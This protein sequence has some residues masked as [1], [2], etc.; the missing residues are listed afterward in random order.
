MTRLSRYFNDCALCSNFK[1]IT[2]VAG[3]LCLSTPIS[4]QNIGAEP[5]YGTASLA[6]GFMPDPH[7]VE[8]AAGGADSVG[9]LG[10]DCV[11]FIA[12]GQPDYD[13][14]YEADS[15]Q[16]GFFVE[17]TM[18]TTLVIN[19]PAGNWHCN[20]DAAALGATNPGILFGSPLS[21]NYNIWVG[22]YSD[23]GVGDSA[24]LVI[25]EWDEDSWS[26]L[27]LD[28]NATALA[29]VSGSAA[30][31]S[32]VDFGDDA[33]TWA[34][35]DECDDQ[36]FQGRGMA[37]SFSDADMFHDASD[38]RRLFDAGSI[39]LIN[40]ANLVVSSRIERGRLRS[41][42]STRANDS[43]SDTFTFIADR[44]DSA[45]ID[46]RSGEFDTYLIVRAPGGEEF[47]N[48]DYESSFDRSLLSLTLTETGIYE[49]VVSSYNPGETGGY[50]VQIETDAG[51][52]ADINT[53]IQG[54][55]AD[56]D[57]TFDSG[58]FNDS[59]S[60][61]GRPGQRVTLDLRSDEFDT[62]LILRSPNGESLANDD[63]ENTSHS[64]IET[65]L[66]ELG[67]YE[68]IVTSFVAAETGGYV[69]NSRDGGAA[70]GQTVANRDVINLG[71][72]D[73]I[74]ASLTTNDSRSDDR[75]YEDSY[76][77]SA[78]AGQSI[79]VEMTSTA[80]DTYLTLITPSGESIENDDHQGSTDQ[81]LVQLTLQES[82]RYRVI[83]SS[84]AEGE[85][86]AYGLSIQSG[87]TGG[88]ASATVATTSS[89]IYGI[90][91]GIADYPGEGNDL[92]LTDQDA[93]RARDALIEGAGM[94]PDNA[95]TLIDS[96]AT[97]QNF[98]QALN[99][100]GRTIDGDDTLVIFFSGHGNRVP[101][102]GGP[103]SADPD[104]MD[105]TMELYDGALLDDELADML[106]NIDAGKILLVMDSCFSGGF[107]KDIISKPG[108]MGLFSSEEDVTSQVAF[109][110]QAGGY[111][112]VFFDEAIR[113]GY[114]DRDNNGE[115][116]AIE[117]SQYLHDR[118]RA[119]VKSF[120]QS[121]YVRTSGVQS[122]YQ[123][124]VVD[125]GGIGPYSVLFTQ[126]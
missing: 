65:E 48:D 79:A 3:L 30:P 96:D 88:A 31:G 13:L 75:K 14:N 85:T 117:L 118:Y 38:C 87:V 33:S 35:D 110:F 40:G 44:G 125:R 80:V 121:D 90:F 95:Y 5:L 43:Y 36:R 120:G 114:A 15:A 97:R 53:Q 59:Y 4:A 45:V 60:F 47:T 22:S 49:V 46:L 52:P 113:G 66:T 104:G 69:L 105:E 76:V 32:G 50:T 27:N 21:G 19:D 42:D 25:T 107:S 9:H 102:A 28:G 73:S 10:D 64:S 116:T 81:S 6:A 12:S 94:N 67:S 83:A 93:R 23:D 62:Y 119:D 1:L 54:E 91:A 103:D 89:Q 82:G 39:R 123:H 122:T 20:D 26:S 63:A 74:Q 8:L 16:L 112:S 126:N 51:T 37:S 71:I 98:Q 92:S 72:G 78:E 100:I 34:N 7:V 86:G 56:G 99:A 77:F 124:L 11:G 84:Y 24:K 2:A 55:L 70:A 58:E 57:A 111:L 17:A 115:L 29:D 18:D 101:R 109:K 41:G 108:R 61:E 106:D 68:V